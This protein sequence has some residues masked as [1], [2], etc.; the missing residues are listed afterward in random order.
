MSALPSPS[1]WRIRATVSGPG[2][3]PD[4]FLDFVQVDLGRG[5]RALDALFE[6]GH[7]VGPALCCLGHGIAHIPV[8]L[9]TAAW[10]RV[11]RTVCR[12]G[13]LACTLVPVYLPGRTGCAGIWLAVDDAPEATSSHLL[14]T[15]LHATAWP[16]TVAA[17]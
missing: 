4:A 3:A 12:T 16:R 1:H 7:R 10:W 17:A 14:R 11:P 5:L 9:G 2:P 6:Q 13:S 8:E 15:R